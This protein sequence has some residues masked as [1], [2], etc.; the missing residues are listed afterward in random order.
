MEHRKQ[1]QKQIF[2]LAD[3][4]K[5]SDELAKSVFVEKLQARGYEVLMFNEPLDEIFV[6][7][8]KVWKKIKFQDVA[9]AG[10]KFG[11]EGMSNLYILEGIS[12][13]SHCR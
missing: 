10:L 1:G 11:D 2:Y 12:L 7:N 5:T 6:Q 13:T 4:A 8:I 9:K 3:I